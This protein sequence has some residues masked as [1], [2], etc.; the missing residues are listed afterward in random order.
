MDGPDDVL[1]SRASAHVAFEP[2]ANLFVGWFGIVFEQLVRR[3]NHAWRAEAA[4]QTVLVP[5]RLLQGMQ[6]TVLGETFDGRNRAAVGLDGETGARPDGDAVDQNRAR[7]ALT[8]IAP[9]FC[10][11]DAAQLANEMGE[12]QARL[13]IAL[14]STAVHGDA[15]GNFHGATSGDG[16][17]DE[18]TRM[19]G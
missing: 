1:I 2:M 10:S 5:E 14:V 13:D 12:E 19:P 17:I 8:G 9:D 18:T 4:L 6:L 15:D 11:G 3:H 16:S 7:T